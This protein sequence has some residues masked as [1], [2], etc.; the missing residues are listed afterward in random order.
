MNRPG[1]PEG[2]LRSAQHDGTPVR[3]RITLAVLAYNQSRF[4][5]DAVRS[6]LGQ[7]CEPVEVLLSD[8]ASPDTTFAQMQALA[9]AYRG[10]HQV[11]L[12]RNPH[13][14]GIGEHYNE[15]LRA[16]RGE[17]IVMMAGDDL[18]LPERVALSAKAWDESGGR[19]DLIACDLVD[20]SHDGADLGVLEVDDLARWKTLDDWARRRPYIVGAGHA[21]TRRLFDRFGPLAPG[22]A[23]EDQVNLLRAL[24]GGGAVTLHQPLVRYR[25]GGVSDRMREFS[26]AQYV[27]WTRRQSIKHVALHAQWLADA[28]IAGCFDLVDR[29]T[30]REHDREL[31]IRDLLAA[32]DLASR[33]R[34]T[35]GAR[36]V[37]LGWRVRKLLYWQW[38]ALG[39]RVRRLQA[40][41]KRLRHGEQR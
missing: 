29:A 8:D 26:G 6:A 20:M 27:A 4:I 1:R 16:A 36:S 21:F 39:A 37:D 19:L 22:V 35:R 24:C 7:V 12:R 5:D 18:S 13:N 17:L 23:Y 28:R 33:L 2:E 31:F 30:R 40:Q 9:A 14:L 38:P 34:V 10:P 25:R 41:S 15:V 3:P 11:V 32:P